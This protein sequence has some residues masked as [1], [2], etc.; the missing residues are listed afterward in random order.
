MA[1]S[2][3]EQESAMASNAAQDREPAPR[4]PLSRDR[5]LRTA[6]ELADEHGLDWLSMRKLGQALGVEAMSLYHHVANRD[7]LVDGM[8]D[9]VFAEIELPLEEVDWRSAMR[10]RAVSARQ[11]LARHRWANG[12]MESRS[13]P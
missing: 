12:L 8:I 7:D 1:A 5:I 9:L 4:V 2:D 10:A 6:L 13:T 11:V 3:D